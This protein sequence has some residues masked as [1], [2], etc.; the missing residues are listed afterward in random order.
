MARNCTD[1]F[2]GIATPWLRAGTVTT[3]VI[4]FVVLAADVNAAVFLRYGVAGTSAVPA[5]NAFRV[6]FPHWV[7]RYPWDVH[8]QLQ[9]A[10]CATAFVLRCILHCECRIS[11]YATSN[12]YHCCNGAL[13][14]T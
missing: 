1:A 13:H 4:H 12:S 10:R 6:A 14:L 3:M 5:L 7:T 8:L 9:T 11:F 2:A